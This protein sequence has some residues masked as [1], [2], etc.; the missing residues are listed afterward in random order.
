MYNNIHL[1]LAA[2]LT[3]PDPVSQVLI[4]VP[5]TLLYEFSIWVSR[6]AVKLRERDLKKAF[7][8][9]E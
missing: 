2:F 4:A 6:V 8:E 7:G 5:L 9:I 3:P 1:V